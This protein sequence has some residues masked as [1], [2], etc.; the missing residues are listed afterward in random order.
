[1]TVDRIDMRRWVFPP[2]HFSESAHGY[3]VSFA[4]RGFSH[5]RIK[6]SPNPALMGPL[7]TYQSIFYTPGPLLLACLV[8][9]LVI[10]LGLVR[11]GAGRRHARWAALTLALSSVL[12]VLSPSMFAQFSYRYGLPL[13]V[14]LPPAG[15]AAAEI[16]LDALRARR[17][18]RWRRLTPGGLTEERV[19][20]TTA[21]PAVSRPGGVLTKE[22]RGGS[23]TGGEGA[24]SLAAPGRAAANGDGA[25][26]GQAPDLHGERA[27]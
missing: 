3:H 21:A 27:G 10:G 20:S 2:P 1:M 17:G 12:V 6:A 8:G 23:L 19:S 25:R 26:P 11:R 9:A 22:E 7:R 14:L 13:L 18:P 24:G 5:S 16:G 15:A 4:T